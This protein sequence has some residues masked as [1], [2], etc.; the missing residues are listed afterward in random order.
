MISQKWIDKPRFRVQQYKG[1][2]EWYKWVWSSLSAD[3]ASTGYGHYFQQ[4][5]HQ[6]VMT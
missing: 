2:Q 3:W 1:Y 4:T 6:P 5:E